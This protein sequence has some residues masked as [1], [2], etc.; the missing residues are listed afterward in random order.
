MDITSDDP[1]TAKNQDNFVMMCNDHQT[2]ILHLF[3][4][5]VEFLFPEI[6]DDLFM[7]P[8]SSLIGNV[9]SPY[10]VWDKTCAEFFFDDHQNPIF[11][12]LDVPVEF[13]FPE[14]K[15]TIFMLSESPSISNNSSLACNI[16]EN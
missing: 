1:G 13:L 4:L 14:I 10:N 12:L 8:D 3:D 11:H 9:S 16:W 6:K 15:D 5:Q 7:V 2:P